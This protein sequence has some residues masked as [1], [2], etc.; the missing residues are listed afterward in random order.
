[1]PRGYTI[2]F[3]GWDASAPPATA[4]NLSTTITLPV[5]VNPD[6]SAITGPAYEYIVTGAATFTLS[7]P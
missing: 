1:M 3:S 2:V 6:G 5:A 7:Y 4:T